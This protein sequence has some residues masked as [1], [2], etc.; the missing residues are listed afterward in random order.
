M[1]SELLLDFPSPLEYSDARPQ[2]TCVP[3]AAFRCGGS[4][5]N[6]LMSFRPIDF[7]AAERVLGLG[8][9]MALNSDIYFN[10]F[11]AV[12]TVRGLLIKFLGCPPKK[13]GFI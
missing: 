3:T 11:C 9:H 8:L 7:L 6:R 10:G 1:L 13:T 12:S 2:D 5:C 4:I